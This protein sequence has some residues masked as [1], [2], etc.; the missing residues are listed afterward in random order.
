MFSAQNMD[1]LTMHDLMRQAL[2]ERNL[3]CLLRAGSPFACPKALGDGTTLCV[4]EHG[5][6]TVD[7]FERAAGLRPAQSGP[8]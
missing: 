3:D 5:E 4:W 6:C 1:V 8:G 2:A 7:L